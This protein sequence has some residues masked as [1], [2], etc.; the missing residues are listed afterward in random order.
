M[1]FR[2]SK[3]HQILLLTTCG[4]L[5]YYCWSYT[6]GA[7]SGDLVG[8]QNLIWAGLPM[9]AILT[10][11]A[12]YLIFCPPAFIQ[13][14]EA[15]MLFS[16]FGP[17]IFPWEEVLPFEKNRALRL[18]NQEKYLS[19]LPLWYRWTTHLNNALGYEG[20]HFFGYKFIGQMDQVLSAINAY[21]DGF[22]TAE[23]EKLLHVSEKE[24]DCSTTKNKTGYG[25]RKSE[26]RRK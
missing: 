14:D 25:V 10:L 2:S 7:A 26:K 23:V 9:F 12:S 1:T 21:R 24:T 20:I 15:G 13:L 4:L 11:R 6:L 19:M 5:T 3:I 8:R 16:R 17:V 22:S 18:K